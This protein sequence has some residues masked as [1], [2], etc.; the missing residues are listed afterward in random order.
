MRARALAGFIG[1]DAALDAPLH[2]QAHHRAE[3]RVG[4]EGAVEDD[5][6]HF[7][8]AVIVDDHDDDG[9]Q[10]EGGGHERDH[11]FG[12]VGDA[13]DATEDDHAQQQRHGDADA[14]LQRFD[15][16]HAQHLAIQRAAHGGATAGVDDAV[17]DGIGLHARHQEAG[18]DD[19]GDGEGQRIPL[20]AHG[21]FDVVRR[22]TAVAAL[23]ILGLVD[24]RQGA[25]HVGGGR[26]EEAHHPHPEDGTR[27][28]ER[29]GGGHAGD[30]ADAH[31]AGHRHGQGLEGGHAGLGLLALHGQ[32]AHLEETADLHEAGAQAEIQAGA[33]A[34]HDEGLAPD[35][36]VDEMYGCF[37]ARSLQSA[38]CKDVPSAGRDRTDSP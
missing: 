11:H 31:A 35:D 26:A 17:S 25:F 13:L 18:G 6:E 27:A 37:H 23:G 34:H 12:E 30:V 29:D 3:R 22:A 36:A 20:Q 38:G 24:L 16:A 2:R 10:D 33:Q 9:H 14:Q 28:A 4:A 15:R 19:R 8:H 1:V 21:L 7:R 5:A 32:A